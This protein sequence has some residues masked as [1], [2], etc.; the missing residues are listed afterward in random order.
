M[1]EAANSCHLHCKPYAWCVLCVRG[2]AFVVSKA[3][4]TWALSL[5]LRCGVQFLFQHVCLALR[6]LYR[7]AYAAYEVWCCCA[8]LTLDALFGT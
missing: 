6:P 5:K 8:Q 7:D 4:H 2:Q 1:E 3:P